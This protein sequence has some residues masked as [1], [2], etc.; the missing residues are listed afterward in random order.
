MIPEDQG[1]VETATG[2]AD[3]FADAGVAKLDALFGAGYAKANP[4]ALAAYMG[5]CATNLNAFMTAAA[6]AYDDASFDEALAAY[7]EEFPPEPASK[8]KGRR[9]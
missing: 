8:S 7:E 1:P 3:A 2:Y 4:A 9:G 6:A 5:A